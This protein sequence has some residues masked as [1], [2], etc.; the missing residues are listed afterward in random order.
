[1][2]VLGFEGIVIRFVFALVLV[3]ATYNPSTYSYYHWAEGTLP[4]FTPLL[5][6]CGLVLL[7]TWGIYLRA[8]FRSLGVIGLLL[9]GA[10]FASFVWLV[11]DLGWLQVGNV[12]AMT[13]VVL[14]IISLLLAIGMSWSHI[15]RR[16][17]GQV[18]IDD[19]DDD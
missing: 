16:L 12:G 6:I 19:V 17:T 8:T 9:A 15:R 7:I 10:L 5:A 18:D 13:W 1:M 11:Y 3:F 14:V 2:K 4:Q